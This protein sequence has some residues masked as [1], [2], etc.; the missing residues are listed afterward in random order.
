MSSA[1]PQAPPWACWHGALRMSQMPAG[2]CSSRSTCGR[3]VCRCA[4]CHRRTL[5]AHK[6]SQTTTGA[7]DG[8]LILVKGGILV[9]RLTDRPSA[10]SSVTPL[11]S[12]RAGPQQKLPALGQQAGLPLPLRHQRWRG[13]L[14]GA[15][16]QQTQEALLG[17]AA[18]QPQRVVEVAEGL[19][20]PV[21]LIYLLT[22]LSF[23][24]VGAYLVVRQVLC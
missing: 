9:R 19:E 16:P 1:A 21:Q 13:Q 6:A 11:W 15:L 14:C 18:R 12:R 4:L 5:R 22:L 10:P 17:L 8:T 24:V 3:P 2:S 7:A 20:T 23:L